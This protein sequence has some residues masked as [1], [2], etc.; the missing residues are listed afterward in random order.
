MITKTTSAN[1]QQRNGTGVITPVEA[2]SM[3]R[4]TFPSMH[5]RAL[6]PSAGLDRAMALAHFEGFVAA[7]QLT[8]RMEVQ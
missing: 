7:L 8:G 3:W 5:T 2:K 1:K 4:K 6:S